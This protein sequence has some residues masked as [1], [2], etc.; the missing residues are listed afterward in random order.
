MGD[1]AGVIL[2]A[3]KNRQAFALHTN[4]D[5][6]VIL[7]AFYVSRE[8]RQCVLVACLLGHPRVQILQRFLLRRV[9]DVAARAVRVFGEPLNSAV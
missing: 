3:S 6:V 9:I 5:G 7:R 2:V 4:F 1:T 8:V